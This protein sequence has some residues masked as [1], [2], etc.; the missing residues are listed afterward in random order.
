MSI[1]NERGEDKMNWMT[2]YAALALAVTLAGCAG[3]KFVR[4]AD[5]ELTLGKTTEQE[6]MARLGKPFQEAAGLSNGKQTRTISYAYASMGN[7]PKTVGVTPVHGLTL[8]FSDNKLVSKAYMSNMKESA[9]DFDGGK[10]PLVEVGKTTVAQVNT[11]FGPA[12]GEAIFPAIKQPVGRAAIYTYQEM[13]G[14]TLSHKVLTVVFDAQGLVADV[15]YKN[16]GKWD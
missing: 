10:V 14:F 16:Q 13:R 6:V 4:P 12:P 8:V 9:T 5:S 3:T 1:K 15:D 2:K 11:L 7:Q